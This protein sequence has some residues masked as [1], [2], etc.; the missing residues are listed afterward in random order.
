MFCEFFHN[1]HSANSREFAVFFELVPM[2]VSFSRELWGFLDRLFAGGGLLFLIHNS[3]GV[4]FPFRFRS[5]MSRLF[6][7]MRQDT[8]STILMK[9]SG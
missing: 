9:D 8:A 6:P 5:M 7:K 1:N 4:V 2:V 3:L